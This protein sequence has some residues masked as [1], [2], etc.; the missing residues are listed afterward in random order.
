MANI[1]PGWACCLVAPV[2]GR[3]LKWDDQLVEQIFP[4]VAP[5]WGRGLKYLQPPV[6]VLQMSSPP[7]GGVD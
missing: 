1:E 4:K 3:G 6:L 5:V 7:Y 2:W